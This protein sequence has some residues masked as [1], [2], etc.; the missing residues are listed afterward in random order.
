MTEILCALYF[1]IAY[2]TIDNLKLLL[3]YC[4]KVHC[5][6][7]N[8]CASPCRAVPC[9]FYNI[10]LTLFYGDFIS[11]GSPNITYYLSE[12]TGVQGQTIA[13]PCR[14]KGYP[15]PKITWTKSGLAIPYDQRQSVADNGTLFIR[16]VQKRSD[17]G[18]Y[19]CTAANFNGIK[20]SVTVKVKVM[21]K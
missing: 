18:Q 7:S 8:H 14:V 19:L 2:C 20:V 3:V 10:L 16:N 5:G 15:L 9:R 1:D 4:G 17:V 12:V 21:G 11:T 6:V 13:L